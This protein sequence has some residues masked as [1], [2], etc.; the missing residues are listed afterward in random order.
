MTEPTTD[1]HPATR[2]EKWRL[3]GPI[4]LAV[5]GFS[6]GE[7]AL[8]VLVSPYLSVRLGLGAGPIGVVVAVFSIAALLT[9]VPVGAA[10]TA[11]RARWLLGAAG[12]ASTAAFVLVPVFPD[13]VAFT[14]LMALDGV[15]WGTATTV[16]LAVLVA[17]RPAGMPTAA[18]MGW[19]AGFTGLGNSVGGAGGGWVAD[20]AGFETA[21][22]VLA[23]V[24]LASTVVI[25]TSTRRL[26]GGPSVE[27]RDRGV[28]ARPSTS[29]VIRAMPAIV[30]M[31]VVV[32]FYINLVNGVL[33]AFHPV[34]ALAGGL[35]LTQIGILASCRSVASS[36]SRLGSGA[37]FSRVRA[38]SL[39][40]PL[41]LLAALVVFA[42]PSVASSFVLQIPIFLAV[43]LSRGLLRVTAASQAFD[44]TGDDER[45]HG[46]VAGVV[47]SGL[48]VGKV[49]GPVLGG[50]LAEA[51]DVPTMFRLM[52][53]VFV[54][55]YVGLV[56]AARSRAVSTV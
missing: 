42:L 50:V 21:F 31:S 56:V 25:V 23:M 28:G 30:W 43:G 32:M 13:P 7:A 18:A 44:A 4:Y 5:F 10:F 54:V 17:T 55:A 34:L 49:A 45:S 11:H 33:W 41:V 40:T 2:A 6:A 9:R 37:L 24:P 47:N 29:A 3:L 12:L 19:Y 53:V 39:T 27:R 36:V 51:F 38:A 14:V 52:P 15:G 48:D 1:E 26:T 22:V 46:L 16:L 8:H 35:T 20:V